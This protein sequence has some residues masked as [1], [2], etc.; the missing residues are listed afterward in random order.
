MERDIIPYNFTPSSQVRRVNMSNEKK[1]SLRSSL[2]S[3]RTS[4]FV[5][6]MP[7]SP[8]RPVSRAK[9]PS[10]AYSN[11]P[12][13]TTTLSHQTQMSSLMMSPGAPVDIRVV[14]QSAYNET[15]APSLPFSVSPMQPRNIEESLKQRVVY[16]VEELG[17]VTKIKYDLD[18]FPQ[19]FYSGALLC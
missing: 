18:S 16:W 13:S 17:L 8:Q 14:E 11:R 1:S 10:R 3:R 2:S 7:A 9:A 4:K 15:P 12:R 5:D 6:S 19:L